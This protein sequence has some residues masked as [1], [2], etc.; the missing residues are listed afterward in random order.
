MAGR[1][2]RRSRCSSHL[3]PVPGPLAVSPLGDADPEEG[4]LERG[5]GSG[6][7]DRVGLRGALDGAF[8]IAPGFLGALEVDL[9][10]HVGRLGHH[11]D[12]IRANLEEAAG[13]RERLLL[14]TLADAQL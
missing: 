11:D 4:G 10:G 6:Q 9:A 5:P 2:P 8:G 14:P 13:D 12:A 7:V 3:T 1:A